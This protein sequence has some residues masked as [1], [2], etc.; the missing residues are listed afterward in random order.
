MPEPNATRYTSVGATR[1]QRTLGCFLFLN[2]QNG[3]DEVMA[4][5]IH[6]LSYHFNKSGSGATINSS[7]WAHGVPKK[8][9][10]KISQQMK[11]RT[12]NRNIMIVRAI[13]SLMCN[14]VFSV[15]KVGFTRA[16][17]PNIT[18]RKI[19]QHEN[20]WTQHVNKKKI[21]QWYWNS[22]RSDIISTQTWTTGWW[23]VRENSVS[24]GRFMLD[25][26][27]YAPLTLGRS[28]FPWWVWVV[29]AIFRVGA[30]WNF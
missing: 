17:V 20:I 13:G 16:A 3:K 1:P 2:F 6:C 4:S 23:I 19:V 14:Q 5:N 26:A 10:G 27:S 18:R 25:R 30:R 24:W 9:L 11:A 7:S 8:S 22:W 29:I 15:E 28:T 12:F 21:L